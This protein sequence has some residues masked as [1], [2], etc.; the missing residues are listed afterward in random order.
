VICRL[1]WIAKPVDT[2]GNHT[3]IDI[4][5][6]LSGLRVGRSWIVS[7]CRGRA[8]RVNQDLDDSTLRSL[9]R[10]SQAN[11]LDP[12][13]FQLEILNQIIADDHCPSFGQQVVGLAIAL[14]IRVGR[15]HH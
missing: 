8:F 9:V 15:N 1:R 6:Y 11:S 2:C 7:L 10:F 5:G 4:S 13:I 14:H 12:S 3:D